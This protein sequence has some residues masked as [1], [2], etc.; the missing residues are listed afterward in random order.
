MTHIGQRVCMIVDGDRLTG[1]PD[2]VPEFEAVLVAS[3]V[4]S[5]MAG[6]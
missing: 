4:L 6:Q 1:E 5:E 3:A 2:R